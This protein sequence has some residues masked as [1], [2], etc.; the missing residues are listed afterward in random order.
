LEGGR[1]PGRAGKGAGG[2]GRGKDGSYFRLKKKKMPVICPFFIKK[3]KKNV[4]KI[5]KGKNKRGGILLLRRSERRKRERVANA[6]GENPRRR[7]KKKKRTFAFLA[8]ISSHWGG[9]KKGGSSNK[10][11]WQEER[12]RFFRL[13]RKTIP[14][15]G[16]GKEL[17][18]ISAG[19]KEGETVLF[20][21]K[22]KKRPFPP[23]GGV[24]DRKKERGESNPV[25][26]DLIITGRGKEGG[27]SSGEESVL[28]I[29]KRGLFPLGGEKRNRE[30]KLEVVTSE[31][32]TSRVGGRRIFLPGEGGKKEKNA[33]ERSWKKDLVFV[34]PR[35]IFF[36]LQKKKRGGT[37]ET[38]PEGD[39]VTE[40]GGGR[41][42][43]VEELE[44]RLRLFLCGKGREKPIRNS[45]VRPKK[46][47]P[48]TVF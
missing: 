23:L 40:K 18:G 38:T 6:G 4:A 33:R 29:E 22:R 30:K 16:K 34:R 14:P 7:K 9:K 31:P 48:A 12:G 20:P 37:R 41:S 17:G 5:H 11:I 39:H 32:V 46:K 19:G 15:G 43:L 1:E 44:G 26:R 47:R 27:A 10:S 35:T 24:W 3:G 2:G 25:K 45:E 21:G 28:Q 13:T 8:G 36:Y 42:T